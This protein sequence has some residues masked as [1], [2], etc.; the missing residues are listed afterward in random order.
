MDFLEEFLGE[1]LYKQVAEKLEGNEKIKLANLKTGDYVAKAKFD[2]QVEAVTTLQGQL[3][4]RDEDLKELQEKADLTETQ[5]QSISELQKKYDDDVAEI[6]EKLTETRLNSTLEVALTKANSIDNLAVKAHMSSF[7]KDAKLDE[8]D[9]I[10]GLDEQI[11]N[12][13]TSHSYLFN[14][15]ASGVVH[16]EPKVVE[17]TITDE[18]KKRMYGQ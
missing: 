15:K 11:T 1:E 5:Q 3:Q 13:K 7:L 2:E 18:I 16:K 12:L 4:G 10:I 6:T 9:S 14:G 17:P 8:N